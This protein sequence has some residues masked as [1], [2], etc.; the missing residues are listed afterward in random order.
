MIQIDEALHESSKHTNT[1]SQKY[2]PKDKKHMA[3]SFQIY[4]HPPK[5][6]EIST[7]ETRS[8]NRYTKALI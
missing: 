2:T 1:S 8:I 5:E 3:D 6:A 4:P 7:A